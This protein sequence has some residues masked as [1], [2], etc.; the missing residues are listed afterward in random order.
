MEHIAIIKLGAD[1]DV[2]R[3]LPLLKGIKQKYP[4]SHITWITKGDVAT[5]LETVKE[6]DSVVRVPYHGRDV[7]D[8]IYNFD[9]EQEALDLVERIDASE[10]YGFYAVDGFPTAYTTGGEY[11]LNTL[12]DDDLKRNNTKTYQE[13]MFEVAEFPYHHEYLGLTLSQE[14]KMYAQAFLK[15]HALH[16]SKLIGI[17]MGASSRWPSKVW[18]SENVQAFIRLAFHQGYQILLF[19]GPNEQEKLQPFVAHLAQGGITVASNNPLNTKRE[20]AALVSLCSTIITGD[21]LALHIALALKKRTIG[22]FFVTSP[23]EV[24]DYG[25]L[26][27]LIA[28]RLSEFFP[29]KSDQYDEALTKS[30]SSELVF[31]KITLPGKQ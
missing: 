18:H 11:Y 7:F 25:L 4:A 10:K 21:S 2:I 3:T 30:I 31:E 23:A 20:F 5:L 17:H 13:M 14:D 19:G 28:P 24:E 29:E 9:I 22:L 1:G 8:V 27:K 6:I 15:E 16:S 12:F 26:S